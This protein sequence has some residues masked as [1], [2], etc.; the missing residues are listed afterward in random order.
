MFRRRRKV[1]RVLGSSCLSLR[2][3]AKIISIEDETIILNTGNGSYWALNEVAAF[4][5]SRCDGNTLVDEAIAEVGDRWDADLCIIRDDVLGLL[6]GL[7]DAGL[8]EVN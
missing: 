4:V 7:V 2:A 3:E 5:L 1:S 6:S 8:L